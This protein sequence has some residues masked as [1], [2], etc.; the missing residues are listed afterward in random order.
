V[1]Y[2]DFQD[3][4]APEKSDFV[5]KDME[6]QLTAFLMQAGHKQVASWLG[7]PPTYYMEVK[8]TTDDCKTPFSMSN[9]QANLV[10]RPFRG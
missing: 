4:D 3:F 7:K 6:G 2:Q 10:S 5:F 9:Y 1:D 8:T